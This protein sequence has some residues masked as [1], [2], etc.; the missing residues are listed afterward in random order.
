MCSFVLAPVSIILEVSRSEAQTAAVTVTG[1]PGSAADIMG[2]G[3]AAKT[4]VQATISAAFDSLISSFT[5]SLSV[6]ELTLDGIAWALINLVLE[7]MIM[8]TTR[9]VNSGFQGSPAF[10]T[11]LNGFLRDIADRVAGEIIWGSGLAFLCSPFKLNVQLALDLQ[12]RESSR[13]YEAQC[14]LSGVVDNMEGFFAGDFLA[15]GWDGWF[16][17]TLNNQNN[18]YG[19]ML[20]GQ[21]AIS[22][23]IQ[24]AQGEQIEILNWG[25]GF[26]TMEDCEVTGIAANGTAIEECRDVTPGA[27]IETQ[28][29]ETL[30]IPRNRLTLAD[31]I[32]ELVGALLSQLTKEIF[33]GAGGLL[34][35]TEPRYGSRGDYFDR[36][37]GQQAT[38]VNPIAIGGTGA[39]SFDVAI[40]NESKYYNWMFAFASL[41]RNYAGTYKETKYPTASCSGALTTSLN[42]QMRNY[43]AAASSS[44]TTIQTVQAL[45][46]DAGT[47]QTPNTTQATI[48]SILTKYGATTIAQAQGIIANRFSTMQTSGAIHSAAVS[49]PLEMTTYPALQTEVQAFT[50]NLDAACRFNN[51]NNN[52]IPRFR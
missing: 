48:Q 4:A 27:V 12:Y 36:V 1:G 47:L 16:E 43:A 32:N 38:Q 34:G 51:A 28:L 7:E 9:W 17:M 37:S 45:K 33:T 10:V 20:D 26:L 40:Q 22:A 2:A 19:A 6:K 23:G 21:A 24:N 46:S 52:G 35:L 31:E 41:I 29:N 11:D 39:V 44:L 14:T 30:N 13:P 42:N 50:N 8:S 18:P 5:E 15:G 25:R 49:V 3:E